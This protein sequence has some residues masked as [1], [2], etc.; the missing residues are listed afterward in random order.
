MYSDAQ[1]WFDVQKSR[2]VLAINW[3]VLQ[4]LVIPSVWI[5]IYNNKACFELQKYVEKGKALN[6]K[7]EWKNVQKRL[8]KW[9]CCNYF[10]FW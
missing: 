9:R 4:R 5:I 2:H 1:F 7:D 8:K 3:T 6:Q 10:M